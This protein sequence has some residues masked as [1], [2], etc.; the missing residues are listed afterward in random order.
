MAAFWEMTPRETFAAMEAA[1]WRE[2]RQAKH[3]VRMAWINANWQRAK[4]MP[5]LNSVLKRSHQAKPLSD[6][7]KHQRVK[8]FKKM[9]SPANIAAIN[10]HMKK[11]KAPK[12]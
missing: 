8:E 7:E 9:A 6:V 5:S 3:D 10:E 4:R 12:K 1:N 2:E 11:L